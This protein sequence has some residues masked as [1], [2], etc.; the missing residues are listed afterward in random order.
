[1]QKK[2]R[3]LVFLIPFFAAIFSPFACA[4][5]NP[6]EDRAALFNYDPKAPLDIQETAVENKGGVTL[7]TISYAS[8]KAG[9]VPAYLVVPAGR[10]P[11]PAIIF[12]HWGQGNRSAFLAEALL[13]GRAGAISLLIDAPFER[14]EPWYR[15]LGFDINNPDNDSAVYIQS[16]VELR[17]AIDLLAARPDVDQKR[18]GYIGLSFGGHIG[19]VLASVDKRIKTYIL[20]GGPASAT[21]MLRKE[22]FAGLVQFRKSV[23]KEKFE[24]YLQRLAPLDAIHYIG[25]AAPSPVFFQFARQDK[26]IS[27]RQAQSYVEAASS[28]KEVKW[29]DVGHE[30][31]DVD[32]LVD[33]ADWLR[34]EIGINSV[35]SILL[36]KL[37]AKDKR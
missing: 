31:N 30:F 1:M 20:M 17:R 18:I 25:R 23:P 13:Y 16:I 4:Q 10:G 37:N 19:G 35:R 26:F 22:D 28:P 12:M 2:I 11:F 29:Y 15:A 9:R 6:A 36:E 3:A 34:K 8:P 27:E 5:T 33:R 24:G 32:S 14:P 7:H 21:D